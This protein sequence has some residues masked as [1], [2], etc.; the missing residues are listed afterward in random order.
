[1]R[2]RPPWTLVPLAA[3]GAAVVIAA[4]LA[5]DVAQEAEI[6]T[7]NPAIASLPAIGAGDE[8]P[9]TTF[10]GGQGQAVDEGQDG[11]PAS[12]PAPSTTIAAPG[13]NPLPGSGPAITPP[14]WIS[15][16][17]SHDDYSAVN[18][19][20]YYGRWQF[21]RSTWDATATG[22]HRTDLVGVRPDLASPADQ[23]AMAAALWD[24]GAG[25]SNW[26]AC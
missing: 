15:E 16:R 22:A 5:R 9:P 13:P 1:M 8:S 18:P 24:G 21:S 7:G 25:C 4:P 3:A 23:D 12:D 19:A 14:G 20:G 2:R 10:R 17:E 6:T 26:A 11:T